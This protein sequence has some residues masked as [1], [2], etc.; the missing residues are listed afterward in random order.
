MTARASASAIGVVLLLLFGVVLGGVVAAGAEAVAEAAGEPELAGGAETGSS[1]QTVALS[2]RLDGD[3]VALTHEA[4]PPL[5]LSETRI[6]VAV[7]GEELRYQ[8]PVPFFA[9]RGFRGGPTGPFNLASDGVWSVGE[10]GSFRVAA[11]NAPA[12]RRGRTV[13][14][15]VYVDSDRVSRVRGTVD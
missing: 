15:T 5:D 12:L 1:G 4:G 3:A 9:A 2:L 11:T 6:V 8:P 14:V 10:T 7:D 13:S